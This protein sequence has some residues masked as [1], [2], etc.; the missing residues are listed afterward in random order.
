MQQY[1]PDV[2]MTVSVWIVALPVDPL[3]FFGAQLIGMKA[4]SGAE[5]LHSLHCHDTANHDPSN[6]TMVQR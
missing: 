3:I 1:L 2:V 5:R 4:M 6:R